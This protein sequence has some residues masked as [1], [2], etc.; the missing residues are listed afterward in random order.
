MTVVR[1]LVADDHLLVREGIRHVLSAWPDVEVVGLAEDLPSLLAGVERH[2]PDVVVS[3]LRMPPSHAD[4]GLRAAGEFARTHP[5]AGFVL[6]SQFLDVEVA[7]ALFGAGAQGR[8]YLLKDSVTRGEQLRHAVTAVAAG[9]CFVDPRVVGVL[10]RGSGEADQRPT[11]LS[12][13]TTREREVLQ[14]MAAGSSNAAIAAQL[15]V[16]GR[17]VEKHINSIFSKLGLTEEVD[18]HRR[19]AAVLLHLDVAG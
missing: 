14:L 13:L 12:A 10:V 4:E 5:E 19:V 15:F 3:D 11:A 8:S 9:G 18:V 6:L 16:T 17:A 2:A 1:V 7:A